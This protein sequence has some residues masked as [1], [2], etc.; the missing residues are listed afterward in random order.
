MNGPS[1]EA[2][3]EAI[4]VPIPRRCA[5]MNGIQKRLYKG[6]R[7]K[8]VYRRD[9]K[10]SLLARLLRGAWIWPVMAR[11]WN[12]NGPTDL[13]LRWILRN[14]YELHPERMLRLYRELDEVEAGHQRMGLVAQCPNIISAIVLLRHD[15]QRYKPDKITCGKWLKLTSI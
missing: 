6:T 7:E 13:F 2:N 3:R 15:T 4:G 1:K 12:W 8:W 5:A 14:L 10:R 11:Y 9:G